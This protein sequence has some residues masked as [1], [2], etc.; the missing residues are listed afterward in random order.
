MEEKAEEKA[1]Q[2]ENSRDW[3]Q[4][5]LSLQLSNKMHVRKPAEARE[6]TT[7]KEQMKQSSEFKQHWEQLRSPPAEERNPGNKQDIHL[8]TERRKLGM[9]VR[10]EK[11]MDYRWREETLT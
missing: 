1:E 4:F 5:P 8:W 9:G 10:G 6:R 11:G 7:G 2:L 3:R